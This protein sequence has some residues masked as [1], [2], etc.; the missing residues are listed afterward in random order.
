MCD[1]NGTRLSPNSAQLHLVRDD[2]SKH[3]VTS[4][5][6]T[7][8]AALLVT[9]RDMPQEMNGLTPAGQIR[10]RIPQNVTPICLISPRLSDH[11]QLPDKGQWKTSER[12]RINHHQ[13][14]G[15][16]P[17]QCDSP[18]PSVA[19]CS[20]SQ[21]RK[22]GGCNSASARTNDRGD[23]RRAGKPVSKNPWKFG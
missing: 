15:P 6:P 20:D 16:S 19:P 10:L 22:I 8:S 12:G 4:K 14:I 18:R 2:K 13:T 7:N 5:S 1:E 3:S 11:F 17:G 9:N 23:P 21:S